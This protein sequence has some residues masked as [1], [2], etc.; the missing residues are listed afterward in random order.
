M[1]VGELIKILEDYP[2]G[3]EIVAASDP[4]GNNF[5]PVASYS[6]QIYC[7]RNGDVYN[8]EEIDEVGNRPWQKVLVLWPC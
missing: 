6:G 8:L 7:P 4:E 5:R 1:T 2:P 3:Q